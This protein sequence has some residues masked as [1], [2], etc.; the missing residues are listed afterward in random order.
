M[1]VVEKEVTVKLFHGEEQSAVTLASKRRPA[2]WGWQ[3]LGLVV[4]LLAFPSRSW[5]FERSAVRNVPSCL[6]LL[7]IL[8]ELLPMQLHPCRSVA[9]RKGAVPSL[10]QAVQGAVNP[11]RKMDVRF[12]GFRPSSRRG[13]I[14]GQADMRKSYV[15]EKIRFE[16]DV[17]RLQEDIQSIQANQKEAYRLI[18]EAAAKGM[19]LNT[20]AIQAGEMEWDAHDAHAEQSE[21]AANSGRANTHLADLLK[22]FDGSGGAAPTTP[23]SRHTGAAPMTPPAST[24]LAV[25]SRGQ[26][27]AEMAGRDPYMTSPGAAHF[28]TTPTPEHGDKDQTKAT[29]KTPSPSKRVVK[30]KRAPVKQLPQKI[31]C[32][33]RAAALGQVGVTTPWFPGVGQGH[34]HRGC[35][36]TGGCQA[37]GSCKQRRPAGEEPADIDLEEE[38]KLQSTSPGFGRLEYE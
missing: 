18:Q 20:E 15:K 38:D 35:P 4:W 12:S 19:P 21:D 7:T 31:H 32:C 11:A 34:S 33:P 17:M 25:V 22:Q 26:T 27:M 6:S 28:G 1:S 37:T 24:G 13:S 9:F 14:A 29:M 16:Q 3:A 2:W 23:P 30:A 8:A 36:A 5:S 10:V